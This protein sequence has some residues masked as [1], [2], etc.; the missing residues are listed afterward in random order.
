M[1]TIAEAAERVNGRHATDS[2]TLA[3]VR[4][5]MDPMLLPIPA[6]WRKLEDGK[7]APNWVTA[8]ALLRVAR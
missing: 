4:G 7:L 8:V 3:E 6:E 5:G 2:S 1:P